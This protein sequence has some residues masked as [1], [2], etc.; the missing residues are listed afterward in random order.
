MSGPALPTGP[1]LTRQR[2]PWL[3]LFGL[4]TALYLPAV[5][6]FIDNEDAWNYV[7]E[8]SLALEKGESAL[9]PGGS[10]L[11]HQNVHRLLPNL[12]WL[13]R[14]GLFGLWMPAWKVPSVLVHALNAV[15]VGLLARRLLRGAGV[16]RPDGALLAGALF[17][18]SPLHA[19]P[20]SWLGGTYDLFLGSF[21]L[22][23]ALAFDAGRDRLAA[24]LTLGACLS[25]EP[26]V[27]VVPLL[28]LQWLCFHRAQGLRRGALRLLLPVLLTLAAMGLRRWQMQGA[29]SGNDPMAIRAIALSPRA[30]LV[31]APLAALSSLA[32]PLR[33]W[34][35]SRAT[36]EGLSGGA[37]AALALVA[38]WVGAA[39][40]RRGALLGL[41]VLGLGAS[42]AFIAP[43]AL[44]T[45]LG[46]PIGLEGLVANQRYL[47]ISHAFLCLIVG[48]A[49][50]GVVSPLR[51]A[52][53]VLAVGLSVYGA[54]GA[55]AATVHPASAGE[56]LLAAVAPLR[57]PARGGGL[58]EVVL[59]TNRYREETFRLAL[60]RW[61]EATTG[62]AVKWVDRGDWRVIER[63]P[64]SAP[65]LDFVDAYVQVAREP[66]E[67]AALD[68]A[69][70]AVLLLTD[71][72]PDPGHSVVPVTLPAAG[73]RDRAVAEPLSLA[74]VSDPAGLPFVISRV[75]SGVAAPPSESGEVSPAADG[76]AFTI[77][78]VSSSP[79]DR[80]HRA[81]AWLP[82]RLDPQRVLGF[83]L[84][85]VATG[86]PLPNTRAYA[87]GYLELHWRDPARS[88]DQTYVHTQLALDDQVHTVTLWMDV[89]PIWRASPPLGALGL[90][91]LDR[92]GEVRV[93]ALEALVVPEP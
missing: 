44:M 60:S 90:A 15:L 47:Y 48:P 84:T 88:A 78:E 42:V 7:F 12:S 79:W 59:L 92:E 71:A 41:G 67:P 70:V 57:G 43:M 38:G 74:V 31:D 19:Q 63:R 91:P 24:A 6:T 35:P 4:V 64:N 2:L 22:G 37:L 50:L 61:L 56:T 34:W 49:L 65:G 66:F 28:A 76:V 5:E 39:P 33:E 69:H 87:R 36:A 9:V 54:V 11:A 51:R 3:V 86:G 75:P 45:E 30:L 77:G 17:G 80:R 52:A 1:S 23:A 83:R 26:G 53:A 46:Q 20:V 27:M 10:Y 82:A 85:Y 72:T 93:L 14:Y 89:D 62:S 32:V 81:A 8:A 25:K 16:E 21:A 40:Q 13:P 18:L 29:S 55:V 58:S 73:A 68:R